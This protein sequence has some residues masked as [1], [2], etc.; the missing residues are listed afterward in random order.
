LAQFILTELKN[1]A[2]GYYDIGGEDAASLKLRLTLIEQNGAAASFYLQLAAA[3]Q[4]EEYRDAALWALRSFTGDFAQYG[5]HA[6]PF[7]R[8]L[9][10]FLSITNG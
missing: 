9:G 1:P 3:T 2:G 8:A 4:D 7:G 10:E 6:A 5:V